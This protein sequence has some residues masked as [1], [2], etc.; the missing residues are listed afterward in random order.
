MKRINVSGDIESRRKIAERR[1]PS[2]IQPV[3]YPK[4]DEKKREGIRGRRGPS[5]RQRPEVAKTE[6]RGEPLNGSRS[7]R[8][9]WASCSV[10]RCRWSTICCGASVPGSSLSNPTG[11]SSTPWPGPRKTPR[12]ASPSSA[13]TWRS[14]AGRDSTAGGGKRLTPG[15]KAYYEGIRRRKTEEFIRRNRKLLGRRHRDP[16]HGGELLADLK[17]IVKKKL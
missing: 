12:T 13:V 1:V 5:G 16:H 6:G 11:G 10:T 7:R 17:R 4:K 15:R 8:P 2:A 9:A 3:I 14:T